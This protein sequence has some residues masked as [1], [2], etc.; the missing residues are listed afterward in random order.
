MKT[1]K[2]YSTI[3]MFE[4]EQSAQQQIYSNLET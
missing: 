2:L 3:P 1:N 4:I